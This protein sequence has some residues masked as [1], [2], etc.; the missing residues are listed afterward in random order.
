MQVSVVDNHRITASQVLSEGIRHSND[1]RIAVAFVS[2]KGY[3]L[4]ADAIAQSLR[5]G[6]NIELLVGMDLQGTEPEALDTIY[7]LSKA[8]SHVSLY[9][10]SALEPATVYHPKMYLLRHDDAV[11]AMVGS[12]NL[13]AGG[14]KRNSEINLAV[15]GTTFDD[16]IADMYESYAY[17]KFHPKRVEP[18]DEF[19]SL[20][21]QLVSREKRMRR[22]ANNT[23]STRELRHAL[24]AKVKSLRRPQRTPHDIVGGW[25]ETVYDLLP[26]GQFTNDDMY[27]H[28]ELFRQ[29]YPNNQNIQAKVRQQLQVLGRLGFIEHVERGVWRKV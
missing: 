15:E 21:S 25:L 7:T 6:G 12:S 10:Y 11:T 24:A 13:T 28:E 2:Q 19:L 5:I 4:I 1:I 17:L 23:A 16:V 29:Q 20:Y 22:E 27:A 8:D 14:L 9:C 18:D 26:E 3:D